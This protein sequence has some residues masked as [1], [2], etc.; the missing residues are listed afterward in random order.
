MSER[1]EFLY[2]M[3]MIEGDIYHRQIARYFLECQAAQ[4][5]VDDKLAEQFAY[6]WVKSIRT[7]G[8]SGEGIEFRNSLKKKMLSEIRLKGIKVNGG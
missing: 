8:I 2:S 7:L 4:K 1:E 5:Q 3:D 6:D